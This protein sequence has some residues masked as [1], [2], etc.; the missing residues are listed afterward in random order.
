MSIT[1]NWTISALNCIPNLEGKEDYVV[2]AHYRCEGTDGTYVGSVYN[3]APFTQDPNKTDYVPFSELTEEMVIGW[4]KGYLGE[5]GVVAAEN[6][7]QIQIQNQ[8]NPPI[9][10]PPLPWATPA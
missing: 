6:A 9:I 10:T 3:T 2:T 4:V 8:I 5:E 1:Y 7:I